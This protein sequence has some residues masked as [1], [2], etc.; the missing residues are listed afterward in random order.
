[1]RELFAQFAVDIEQ[2][3]LRFVQKQEFLGSRGGNLPRKLRANAPAGAGD[4]Y[5]LS[6]DNFTHF[7]GIGL[8]LRTLQQILNP[9][10]PN[11]VSGNAATHQ[12]RK[13]GQGAHGQPRLAANREQ[14]A[15]LRGGGA[16]NANQ[17]FVDRAC[18][19]CSRKQIGLP[20]DRDSAN[21]C[22]VGLRIIVKDRGWAITRLGVR[23]KLSDQRGPGIPGANHSDALEWFSPAGHLHLIDPATEMQAS[24]QKL[25]Q[26][27]VHDQQGHGILAIHL[28]VTDK[29]GQD[30][31]AQSDCFCDA[32][33]LM[34]TSVP[35]GAAEGPEQIERNRSQRKDDQKGE[36]QCQCAWRLP[37]LKYAY[38]KQER[39]Q[40]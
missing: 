10:A 8:Q 37:P 39:G 34:N 13:S 26:S 25:T 20:D 16:G 30:K 15:H 21:R 22:A 7:A 23:R 3:V 14:A 4:E 40:A 9:Q 5:D 31:T 36:T 18:A 1:M 11:V 35:K 2:A 27:T 28:P 17:G 19:G 6:F 12:L 32:Q 38:R 33:Q 24:E 29:D